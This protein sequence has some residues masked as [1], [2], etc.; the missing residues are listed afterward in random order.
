M[1]HG[2]HGTHR[3]SPEHISTTRAQIVDRI[4]S[5]MSPTSP[6][7][8]R[9]H[10]LYRRLSSERPC[11]PTFVTGVARVSR[12]L[13][14]ELFDQIRDVWFRVVSN[15]RLGFEFW[16][17]LPVVGHAGIVILLSGRRQEGHPQQGHEP[18]GRQSG[19]RQ[20]RQGSVRLRTTE[21]AHHRRAALGHMRRQA[22]RC[23]PFQRRRC[24]RGCKYR[25]G[26]RAPWVWLHVLARLP[27]HVNELHIIIII[28][29]DT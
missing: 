23:A 7:R 6:S 5:T 12:R 8:H 3:S 19:G 1:E 4:R 22:G 24:S 17:L 28:E 27:A 13:G 11:M 9:R 14:V 10:R 16:S 15:R 2:P 21:Q 26:E 29:L 20:G 25:F 18:Q